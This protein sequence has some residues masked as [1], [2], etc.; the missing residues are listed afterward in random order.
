MTSSLKHQ[1]STLL[2]LFHEEIRSPV[3]VKYLMNVVITA[4]FK[5]NNDPTPVI[6]ADQPVYT[7]SKQIQWRFANTHGHKVIIMMGAL[8]IEMML[9]N[10]LGKWLVNSGWADTLVQAGVTSKGIAETCSTF[11]HVKR[12]R[13]AHEITIVVLHTQQGQAYIKYC[14]ETQEHVKF[15]HTQT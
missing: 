12:A 13:F 10:I 6:T 5:L 15:P 11:C 3:M 1:S 4:T 14:E 2:P 8:H 7:I 9:L